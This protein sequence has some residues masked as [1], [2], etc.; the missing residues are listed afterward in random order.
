M[1][2]EDLP[3]C[4]GY[5]RRLARRLAGDAV[6]V[7]RCADGEEA[8]R[9]LGDE[10]L[11]FARRANFFLLHCQVDLQTGGVSQSISTVGWRSL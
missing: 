3:C 10:Q 5:I 2:R 6:R 4:E 1:A 7:Q 11:R 8:L 9:E